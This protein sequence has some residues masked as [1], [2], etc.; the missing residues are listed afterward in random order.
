M[1]QELAEE[2]KDRDQE[3][4]Q[5]ELEMEVALPTLTGTTPAAVAVPGCLKS[6]QIPDKHQQQPGHVSGVMSV[7]VCVCGSVCECQDNQRDGRKLNN[8]F[9][10]ACLGQKLQFLMP[11]NSGW[12]TG[13]APL[14][15]FCCKTSLS[16]TISG[17]L[18]SD[19]FVS[20]NT[21]MHLIIKYH[22]FL[23]NYNPLK[24]CLE[25]S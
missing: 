14:L 22:I 25:R 11:N 12:L 10:I 3:Q 13:I 16:R 2:A 5:Q 4:Q 18:F 19:S 15:T 7:L 23:Q 21:R 24:S 8:K 9:P 20:C 1:G 17:F 6:N